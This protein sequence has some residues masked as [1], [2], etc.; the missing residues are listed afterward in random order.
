MDRY[1]CKTSQEG[2]TALT[3]VR[4]TSCA[5]GV[6]QTPFTLPGLPT[7]VEAKRSPHSVALWGLLFLLTR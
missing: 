6:L 7:L 2:R 5:K 1:D 4:Y 3:A